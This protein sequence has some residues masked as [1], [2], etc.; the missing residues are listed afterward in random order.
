MQKPHQNSQEEAFEEALSPIVNKL[1]DR[2]YETSKDKIASQMA[3]LIGS[4]IREQIKSQK[5]DV[6]DALYP[7]MGNMISKYITQALEDLLNKINSQIQDGLSTKTLKRKLKAK[8]KGVS[9]TELLI[10]EMANS[11]VEAVLLIHK[12]SG[13][14]LTHIENKELH[15][16]EMLGSMMTAI[17]SFVNDWIDQNA[18]HQELGEIDYGGNKIILEASGYSYLAVIVKGGAYPSL[19]EK[20][21]HVMEKIVLEFSQEIKNFQGDTTTLPQEEIQKILIPLLNTQEEDPNTQEKKKVHP[22]MWI[23]PVVFLGVIGYFGYNHYTQEKFQE[24]LNTQLAKIPQMRL[25]NIHASVDGKTVILKG[26]TP[27]PYYKTLAQK[28]IAPLSKDTQIVNTIEVVPNATTP[29][30]VEAKIFYLAKGLN[31][32]EGINIYPEFHYPNLTLQGDVENTQQ[33]QKVLQTFTNI[34]G[35]KK[36]TNT[37]SITPPNMRQTLYFAKGS[38]KLSQ[39]A[40]TKL[41]QFATTL[42]NKHLDTPVFLSIYSDMQGSPKKNK[43]LSALRAETIKK[44]LIETLSIKNKLNV[45]IKNKAPQGINPRITP[46]LARCAT[47]S[48]TDEDR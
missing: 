7:V 19:Y 23:V 44:F 20:L 43:H 2:N 33:K 41:T 38:T 35:I 1:I 6:V 15:E 4:A 18:Q 46:H 14:V 29:Q 8:L 24:K 26:F 3:P 36:I 22:L 37:I 28:T 12:E 13:I 16:P 11:N 40:Q 30:M 45:N 5:D 9:E 27:S 47:I 17:R 32:Q 48:L 31:T 39:K 10:N 25:Y 21:R 34:E 42:K